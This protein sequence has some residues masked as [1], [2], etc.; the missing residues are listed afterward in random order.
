MVCLKI[1]VDSEHSYPL[2][3][4][5]YQ[6][7][8]ISTLTDWQ[9]GAQTVNWVWFSRM[10]VEPSGRVPWKGSLTD[11]KSASFGHSNRFQLRACFKA[12]GLR[13][14]PLEFQ[15]DCP[16]DCPDR[17]P[18]PKRVGR[19]IRRQPLNPTDVALRA[20]QRKIIYLFFLLPPPR[21]QTSP[22]RTDSGGCR[23]A[24]AA[25]CCFVWWSET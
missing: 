15:W 9:L 6:E 19:G 21:V 23:V 4:C 12:S 3:L 7:S 11:D 20:I 25:E 5:W 14:P 24:L 10:R 22:D 8:I 13:V 17:L 18:R 1:A 16:A 2:L